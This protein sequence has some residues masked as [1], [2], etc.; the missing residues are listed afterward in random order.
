MKKHLIT[1]AWACTML[2][3][4]AFVAAQQM[5]PNMPGMQHDAKPADAQGMG[6]VKAIDTGKGTITLQHEAIAAIGWPAMTMPFKVASPNLLK[7]AKVGDKVTFT[8]HPAGMA[9][10]L[11]AI[12]PAR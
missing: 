6:V 2:A 9:S 11:T 8:L 4:P 7:V 5:D 12:R 3:A 10:T 1:F